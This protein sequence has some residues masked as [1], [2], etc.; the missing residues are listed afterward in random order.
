MSLPRAL[1]RRVWAPVFVLL[2]VAGVV[3]SMLGAEGPLVQ[4]RSSHGGIPAAWGA[5]FDLLQELGL[6]PQRVRAPLRARAPAQAQWIVEPAWQARDLPHEIAAIEQF[7]RRGGTIVLV[8]AELR[9]LEGFGFGAGLR[10]GDAA[11]A[12]VGAARAGG[13]RLARV[14]PA[15]QL[16]HGPWLRRA[17]RVEVAAHDLFAADAVPDDE[18]RLHGTAGVFA[19]ERA[20]G[21]GRLIVLADAA[22][23]TNTRLGNEDDAALLV[24]L[25][26]ALGAPAFDERCHGLLPESSAWSALGA[27]F[28]LLSLL[29][30][31]A[32][33]LAVV[34]HARRWPVRRAPARGHAPPTLELF[35]GSL[36]SLYRA[37]GRSEPAAVFRAY[38][39]GF[40]R[41][42]ARA[43]SARAALAG[44]GG[45]STGVEQRLAQQLQ[46][47]GVDA[48]WLSEAA[49]PASQLELARAVAALE[50]YAAAAHGERER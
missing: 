50:R 48:R 36:A 22:F 8:G 1:P 21:S 15:P 11:S 23:L 40:L 28:V 17:R 16:L 49:A 44:P 25:V 12:D 26:R 13:T 6:G 39:A 42:L 41:R 4:T 33:G 45:G 46:Q 2:L 9:V 14:E 47:L 35:V 37:R 5:A 31:A 18:V 20:L 7:A 32:L 43:P 3:S 27:G 24:D 10:A 29:S 30:F 34:L 19:L 38:R